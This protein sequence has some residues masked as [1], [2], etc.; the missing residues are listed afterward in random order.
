MSLRPTLV[1]HNAPLPTSEKG[2]IRPSQPHLGP[3]LNQQAALDNPQRYSLAKPGLFNKRLGYPDTPRI[4]NPHN[5]RI[6]SR[7]RC[8]PVFSQYVTTS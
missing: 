2:C 1:A 4:P 7:L 3:R 8:R 6:H 5:H